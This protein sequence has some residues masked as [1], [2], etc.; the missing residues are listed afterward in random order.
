MQFVE[1]EAKLPASSASVPAIDCISLAADRDGVTLESQAPFALTECFKR[2]KT[3]NILP[4]TFKIDA[5]SPQNCATNMRG[6]NRRCRPIQIFCM[7]GSLMSSKFNW[8]QHASE[9]TVSGFKI[10]CQ[11]FKQCFALERF[12]KGDLVRPYFP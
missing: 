8:Q 9:C 5:F 12:L 11:M 10:H 2:Q 7:Q 4:D 6:Q 3:L 1:I